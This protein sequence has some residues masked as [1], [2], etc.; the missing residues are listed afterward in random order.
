MYRKRCTSRRS[1]L[2]VSFF[3]SWWNRGEKSPDKTRRLRI[4]WP[5]AFNGACT[6]RMHEWRRV[7]PMH[8]PCG[9]L[10]SRTQRISLSVSLSLFPFLIRFAI[11]SRRPP[12]F[13]STHSQPF[14]SAFLR[15]RGCEITR[16]ATVP[17]EMYRFY[18]KLL[19]RQICLSASRCLYRSNRHCRVRLLSL[20]NNNIWANPSRTE[21]KKNR[22]K[23]RRKGEI[24]SGRDCSPASGDLMSNYKLIWDRSGRTMNFRAGYNHE[25]VTS[26]AIKKINELSVANLKTIVLKITKVE[27]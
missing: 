17:I 19:M 1:L 20:P 22:G 6:M 16:G 8:P 11:Y 9:T 13:T 15:P 21:W 23:E 12:P 3:P 25:Y 5:V 14:S 18:Y 27:T 7:H 2:V 26:L 24:V 10:A 4:V